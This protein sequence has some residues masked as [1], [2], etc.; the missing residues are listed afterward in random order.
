MSEIYIIGDTPLS[1]GIT[2]SVL[3]EPFKDLQTV[4]LKASLSLGT[5]MYYGTKFSGTMKKL[6]GY[7]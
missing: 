3:G 1:L 6:I 4:A 5:S 7:K 2:F